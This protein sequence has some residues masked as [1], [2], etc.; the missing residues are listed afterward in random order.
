MFVCLRI[1]APEASPYMCERRQMWNHLESD[2]MSAVGDGEHKEDEKEGEGGRGE[3]VGSIL[4]G[5][6]LKPFW[7][8]NA[9]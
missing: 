5:N 8:R 7:W 2:L 1:C 4:G 9:S 3:D 6:Q